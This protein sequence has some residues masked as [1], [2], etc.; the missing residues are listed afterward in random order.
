MSVV[1][2]VKCLA[3][4]ARVAVYTCRIQPAVFEMESALGAAVEAVE[5]PGIDGRAHC[6]AQELEPLR[7]R[8]LCL[9]GKAPC[10][11]H[12]DSVQLPL[13]QQVLAARAVHCSA[14]VLCGHP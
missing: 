6:W 3:L 12:G 7:T 2:R 9:R 10:A 4:I 13:P 14:L 5:W 1:S 11:L 8:L